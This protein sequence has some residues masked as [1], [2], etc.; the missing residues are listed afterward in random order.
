MF[1]NIMGFGISLVAC[2]GVYGGF[3]GNGDGAIILVLL[4]IYYEIKQ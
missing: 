3:I 1:G 4:L 2:L